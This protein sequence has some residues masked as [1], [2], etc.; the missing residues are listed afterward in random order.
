MGRLVTITMNK[1]WAANMV[2]LGDMVDSS[3][4][5]EII[6]TTLASMD[7]ARKLQNERHAF[8]GAQRGWKAENAHVQSH[9][10]EGD[11]YATARA[12]EASVALVDAA[13]ALE[14]RL[15]RKPHWER[16]DDG[17]F[18]DAGLV[19]SGD[20]SPCYHMVR[21]S[22]REAGAG[23]EPVIITISTDSQERT[24]LEAIVAVIR[25]VQQFRPVHVWWQGAWLA[26]D[27]DDRGYV[28][29]APLVTGD[30]DFSRLQYVVEDT[31]RDGLSFG[32]LH[33]IAVVRDR[34]RIR[35]LGR[36]AERTYNPAGGH[37]VD[38]R[39]IEPDAET[40]AGV[41]C[42]WLGIESPYWHGYQQEE[43]S[44]AALQRVPKDC[45]YEPSYVTNVDRAQCGP[46]NL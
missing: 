14:P 8:Q 28:F 35:G 27:G 34:V 24:S 16:S 9:A 46:S 43:A 39:G 5:C 40:V 20:D 1:R 17:I 12:V 6:Q 13:I 30:M 32:V 38:R 42:R 3:C 36:H 19:A 41:A 29:H 25:I 44:E 11:G 2:A 15:A 31:T 7:E 10:V 37:Y 21:K 33:Q 45:E 18:A 23:L 22:L 26:D 4:V